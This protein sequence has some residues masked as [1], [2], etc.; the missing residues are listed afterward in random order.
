MSYGYT[1]AKVTRT[2]ELYDYPTYATIPSLGGT[3][4]TAPLF[5]GPITAGTRLPGVPLNTVSFSLDHTIPIRISGGGVWA[6]RLHIDGA[7]RSAASATI[8]ASTPFNWTIPS[9]F[10][11]DLR[12]SLATEGNLSYSLFITNFTDCL[13]YS[14]GQN[15]QSYPNYSRDRY[16]VR[17]RTYGLTLR[18]DF[19]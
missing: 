6:L 12:A 3:G 17:P 15:L 4:Q 18:Y 9:S 11:G 2:F 13:C 7:Y 5:N 10:S 1:Q 14:G 19:N 8:L 16:I